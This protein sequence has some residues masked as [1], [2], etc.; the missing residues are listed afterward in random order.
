MQHS[1]DECQVPI[2]ADDVCGLPEKSQI[3]I[4]E[5]NPLR[6]DFKAPMLPGSESPRKKTVL[7]AFLEREGNRVDFNGNYY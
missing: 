2:G 6:H 7:E 1:Q 3:H 5:R 4:N